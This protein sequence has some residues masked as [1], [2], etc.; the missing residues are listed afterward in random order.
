MN[1]TWMAENLE[2]EQAEETRRL[3]PQQFLD[4]RQRSNFRV[5]DLE[6]L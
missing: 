5:P 1:L 2:N 3:S 6:V 4:S